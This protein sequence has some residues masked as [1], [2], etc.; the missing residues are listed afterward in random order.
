[1]EHHSNLLPWQMV[2][3]NTGATL[4]FMECKP[5]GSLDLAEVEAQLT[6][7][8]RI[9]AITQVSNVLGRVNPVKEIAEMA[10]RKGAVILVDG[11]QSTPHMAV[12]V[13]NLACDFLAFSG[14]K[15]LGP[16]GIGV[17]YGRQELLEEMPPFLSGGEMIESVTRE[18]AVY[19]EVPHKFEAGT[20]NAAGAV[21]LA[22]AMEYIKKIGFADMQK[23]EHLLTAHVLEEM[24]RMPHV[25]IVG[26]KN[27]ENHTGIVTFTIEDVH[28]HDVSEILSNDGI[29]VRAGHHC[30]QPLLKHLGIGS[31]TRASFMFYNTL[32]EADRLIESVSTI[33]E[34]MGYGR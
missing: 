3:R 8:T 20:V 19:A 17:L 28:P 7:K 26:D 32:E 30:A 13:Q 21:G 5:D 25:H 1:M 6:E 29:C 18:S 15:L 16:M 24:E 27:A 4:K 10:H 14:H 2:A 12:D 9:V 34:R 22:A 33:R 31:A 11:A 23:Q